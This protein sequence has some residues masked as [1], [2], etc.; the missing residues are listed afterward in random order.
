MWKLCESFIA[1]FCD[2]VVALILLII[3]TPLL[4]GLMI[5][6]LITQGRPIFYCPTR[7]GYKRRKIK[8]YKFRTM[9]MHKEDN[10]CFSKE[11]DYVTPFGRWLRRTSLDELPQLINILQFKLSF[12]GLRPLKESEA[13]LYDD[14]RF[15]SLPGGSNP[16]VLM[17]HVDLSFIERQRIEYEFYK[18][19]T[20]AQKHNIFWTTVQFILDKK[21]Y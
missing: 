9:T 15:A 11:L 16:I 14:W 21:N 7:I 5:A 19:C 18:T 8:I 10:A 13:I 20:L 3:F 17:G 1:R 6:C 12:V 4:I 2:F